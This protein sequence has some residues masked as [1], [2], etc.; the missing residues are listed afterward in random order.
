[1]QIQN[2][3]RGGFT[4][5]ELLVVIAIIAILAGLL[6][7]SLT[8]AKLKAQGMQCMNNNRQL[9]LAWRMYVDESQECLPNSK[10][11]PY[12]W[13]GGTL[14]YNP[15]NASNWSIDED[16]VKSPLWP[17]C[18]KNAAIFRCPA[19]KSQVSVRGVAYPR[20]RSMGMLCWV[21]GRGD[22]NGKPADLAWSNTTLG[23]S[24]GEYVVYYKM[25]DMAKPGPSSTFVFVDEPEDR[26]N[27]GFFVV[28]MS[29][30][31]SVVDF[32]ASYHGGGAG[33]SFADGHAEIKVWK[34]GF[35]RTK[36]QPNVVLPYP[37]PVPADAQKDL[38]WMQDRATT[39]IP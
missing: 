11:G 16:I 36:P 24:S 4:L 8:N 12:Q 30:K 19:D 17:Y 23:K 21:G 35:F 5:I 26:V 2:N 22:A 27:D 33:F 39:L 25:S 14:N 38:I 7:P 20:V 32:P 29:T 37:T 9:M 28:D 13:M 15:G 1:M 6:L 10:G 18:G 34:S 31:T 3:R